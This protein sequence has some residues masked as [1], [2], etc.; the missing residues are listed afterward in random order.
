MSLQVNICEHFDVVVLNIEI[1]F[2]NARLKQSHSEAQLHLYTNKYIYLHKQTGLYW[3]K[4]TQIWNI[5]R[6]F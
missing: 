5:A 6:F 3:N 2:N 1:I 4:L